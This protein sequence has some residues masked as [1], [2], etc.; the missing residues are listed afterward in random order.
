[1][2][3]LFIL[4]QTGQTYVYGYYAAELVNS[5]TGIKFKSKQAP[6]GDRV[7]GDCALACTAYIGHVVAVAQLITA[8]CSLR[9]WRLPV[10]RPL[11]QR[12]INLSLH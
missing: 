4:S 1:M 5:V 12:S 10:C 7:D 6:D 8:V 3:C 11:D 2:T 9:A